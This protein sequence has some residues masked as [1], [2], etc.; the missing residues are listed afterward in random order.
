METR[1]GPRN[2]GIQ[3]PKGIP[4]RN[5][6]HGSDGYCIAAFDITEAITPAMEKINR[7][8]IADRFGN[9]HDGPGGAVE[10]ISGRAS[11]MLG[12]TEAAVTRRF[13]AARAGESRAVG[14]EYAEAWLEAACDQSIRDFDTIAT[15]PGGQNA[16]LEMVRCHFEF[17][18]P[19]ETP[20]ELEIHRLARQLLSFTLGYL[21]GVNADITT[22]VEEWTQHVAGFRLNSYNRRP[23]VGGANADKVMRRDSSEDDAA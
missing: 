4:M 11:A 7:E 23:G 14:T 15:L 9:E 16:A 18:A 19:D 12:L 10:I 6:G 21:A 17:N 5:T 1:R 2:R 22:D 8:Q 20:T 13:A 3:T